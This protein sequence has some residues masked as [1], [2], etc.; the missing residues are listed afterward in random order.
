MWGYGDKLLG[1]CDKEEFEIVLGDGCAEKPRA[2][3]YGECGC[4]TGVLATSSVG[5]GL[6]ISSGE[7]C[8]V[9]PGWGLNGFGGKCCRERG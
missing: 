3:M 9:N 2:L 1:G 4:R 5:F 8:G 6:L 7:S